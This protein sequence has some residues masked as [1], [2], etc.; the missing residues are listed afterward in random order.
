MLSASVQRLET[1]NRKM[2][3]ELKELRE[4]LQENPRDCEHCKYY[5]QHYIRVKGVYRE[6][7]CGNCT[8]GISKTRKPNDK[9]NYF[10][11]GIWVRKI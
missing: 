8:H 6:T 4:K 2:K 7:H 11:E 10:E 5:I 1:E 3:E 9:C